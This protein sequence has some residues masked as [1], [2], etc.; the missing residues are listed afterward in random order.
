MPNLLHTKKENILRGLVQ[1]RV[2]LQWNIQ[3]TSNLVPN[4]LHNAF[5]E[6]GATMDSRDAHPALFVSS[7]YQ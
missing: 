5:G 7:F 1:E 4:L 2:Q 3:L 6:I